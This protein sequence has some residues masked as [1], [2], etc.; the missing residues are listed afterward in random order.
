MAEL[1]G[2]EVATTDEAAAI[3][4]LESRVTAPS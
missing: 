3:I 4:G 1:M 2:R